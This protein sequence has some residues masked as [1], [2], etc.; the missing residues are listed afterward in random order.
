[1][2]VLEAMIS[3]LPV[4]ASNIRGLVD[5]L[6]N[7]VT[8]YMFNPLDIDGFAYGIKKLAMDNMLRIKMGQNSSETTGKY[9]LDN[10][11]SKLREIYQCCSCENF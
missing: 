9:A 3:G 6:I 5:C 10:V 4:I 7:G 1:M 8:G 2:A 11:L